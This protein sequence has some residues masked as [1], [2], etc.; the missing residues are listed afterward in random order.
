MVTSRMLG[1]KRSTKEGEEGT[2]GVEGT[3][4]YCLS[5]RLVL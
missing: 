2:E 5:E 1:K 4:F 3:A